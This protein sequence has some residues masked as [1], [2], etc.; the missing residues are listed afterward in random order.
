MDDIPPPRE[1]IDLG[2]IP[3]PPQSPAG[4]GIRGGAEQ[5]SRAM[6]V[7]LA[8]MCVTKTR[9]LSEEFP[10]LADFDRLALMAALKPVPGVIKFRW[11]QHV[12]SDVDISSHHY[13]FTQSPPT[14]AQLQAAVD[15]C[16]STYVTNFCPLLNNLSSLVSVTGIDL[17]SATGPVADNNTGAPGTRAGG[18]PP[19][20]AVA[21]LNIKV[22]RRYRG[23]KPRVYWP[24]GSVADVATPQTW[25]TAFV[26]ALNNAW[27]AVNSDIQ[28]N[29]RGWAPN[30]VVTSVSYYEDGVWKPDHLGNYHRVPTP[31]DVPLVESVIGVPQ[32]STTIGSQRRRLRPN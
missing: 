11:F 28:T 13:Y 17:S 26:T 19:A 21:L 10:V 3:L 5:H 27:F 25:S 9:D 7:L 2:R 8:L 20:N 24:F 32:F 1:H 23:G 15:V 12:G 31:R 16:H 30:A 4:G 22:Q 18:P 6:R 14:Q 29:L